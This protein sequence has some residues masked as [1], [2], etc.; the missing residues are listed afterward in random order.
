MKTA[1]SIYLPDAFAEHDQD[2]VHELIERYSFGML[3]AP[4]EGGAP[5][6]AH[7]PFLLDRALGAQGTLFVHVARANPIRGALEAGAPV[8]AI[9]R[10][11][12]G[13]VSP[14][15]YT[16]RDE[17]PTWNYAV[18]HAHA[19]PRLL[20]DAGLLASLARLAAVHEEGQPDPWTLADLTAETRGRLLPAIAG[21]ALGIT[22]LEAKLK[23]SQNRRPEDR[24]GALRG[25][26]ERGAADDAE[27]AALMVRR[28]RG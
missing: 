15:W 25:L 20:D 3:I 16:S 23:L 7:L 18:V 6:I 13:Y 26:R 17:V 11:P 8:L 14:G 24:D 27:L 10:G 21:F 2:L 5:I 28:A 12:H 4:G 9:F 1:P 19:T 22:A